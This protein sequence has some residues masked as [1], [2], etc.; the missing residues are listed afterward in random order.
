MFVKRVAELKLLEEQ[1]ASIGSNLVILYGRKGMGKT[2]LLTEF[3]SGKKAA[4]YYEGMECEDHLQFQLLRQQLIKGEESAPT[5]DNARLFS[6]LIT[7]EAEKVVLVLDEFHYI[8]KN[9]SSILEALQ[10]LGH[11]NKPVMIVLCSSSIRWVENE[12]L[13]SL[14]GYAS[15]I[16]AYMKLKDF[17]FVDF[18]NRF[19]VSSVETCIYINSILGGIPEYL[20]AWQESQSVKDNIKTIL[21]NKNSGLNNAPQQFLK[22]ELREPAVYNTILYYLAMGNRKLNELHARTGYSRAKISVYI[23]NLIQLDI[24]EK[25]VPLGDEGRENAQK[26]LYRIKD[27]FLCFWYRFVFPNTSELMLGRIDKVYDQCIAPYLDQYIG[28]YFADVCTEFLKLMNLHNRLPA[29]FMWWDRW[30]GK[31][32]TIDIMAQSADKKTLIG[33]CLWDEANVMPQDY[34]SLLALAEE[35]KVIPDYC[36]LFSKK[37][38]SDELRQMTEGRDD[39]HLIGLVDF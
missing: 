14:S 3:L 38:F 4:Y 15:Y 6:E 16:T 17:T 1:Y 2:S 20:D 35:A 32:G 34:L 11:P 12:M 7:E 21:L 22:L 19:P 33:R 10:L 5:L 29:N 31:N 27:N 30:Y 24:V 28:E 8:L 9:G 25:L 26:G 18:V 37:G 36:Y 23:K 39:I 13:E